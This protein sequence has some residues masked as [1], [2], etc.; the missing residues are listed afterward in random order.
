MLGK[1]EIARVIPHAGAMCLLDEV[2]S[3]D[4]AT[5]RCA[6]RTHRDPDNPLRSR[7]ELPALCGIE[8]AAQ[9]MAVHGGLA[10][11]VAAK[12]RAGYLISVRDLVC[13]ERRLDNLEGD[14][15]VEAEQLMGGALGVMYRFSISVGEAEVLS[16]RAT[17]VLDIEGT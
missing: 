16:G 8:Y 12:P 15:V 7:G 1:A 3:W 4:A 2:L 14:L 5:I 9:A 6:S 11:M 13:R 17:V 10:G